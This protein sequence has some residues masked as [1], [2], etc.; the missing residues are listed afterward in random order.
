M[1]VA[2][3]PTEP[4]FLANPEAEELILGGILFDSRAIAKVENILSPEHFYVRSHATIYQTALELYRS[5]L[6]TDLMTVSHHLEEKGVLEQIGGISR[7]ATLIERTVSAANIDSYARNIVRKHWEKRE[8]QSLSYKITEWVEDPNY[9]PAQIAELIIHQAQSLTIA[10]GDK[11]LLSRAIAQIKQ[12]LKIPDLS[13]LQQNAKL[14]HLRSELKI[15]PYQWENNFVQAAKKE[16]R[17]ETQKARLKLEILAYVQTL[18]PYEKMLLKSH[19]CSHY[20]LSKADLNYLV[21]QT[22]K[23]LETMAQSDFS[24]DEFLNSGTVGLQW[25]VPGI[26]PV[27]ETV[28][29]AA[30]AKT[31]KTLLATDIAYGVLTGERV[32]GEQP[33]VKG[34]VLLVT[35]DESGNSTKRRLRA[36]GFDLLANRND[37]RII[38]KLDINDLSPLD[39]ALGE[40]QP[41]LVIIDSLTSITDNLGV[42]E[43]DPEFARSIY[44]LKNLI[45]S[46]GASGILI[47]HEN[48]CPDAKGINQVSGSARIVAATWGVLQ[49]KAVNPDDEQ[50]PRRWLRVKPREGQAVCHILKLNPKDLWA[51]STIFDYVGEFGDENGEK[52]TQGQRVLDLLAR[53]APHGLDYSEIDSYLNIG[54][55]LYTVLDRLEDRQLITK[56][57]SLVN[58][59]RWMYC[60][61]TTGDD[62]DDG[63]G[64]PPPVPDTPPPTE[65]LSNT[66]TITVSQSEPNITSSAGTTDNGNAASDVANLSE[67]AP[68]NQVEVT[69]LNELDDNQTV[70]NQPS[71]PAPLFEIGQQ[72]E[73]YIPTY[74]LTQK[75]R[76]IVN[77]AFKV[78]EWVYLLNDAANTWVH[79]RYLRATVIE[80]NEGG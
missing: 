9:S 77:R 53:F 75:G 35:S 8:L 41:V 19:I 23:E 42:S 72:V 79:E 34:K 66:E 1:T 15:N 28:L 62:D 3:K 30:L 38:T 6:P 76:T 14:E 20:R 43:K 7:L 5:G 27:G 50:D 59:R 60:L 61:P 36:K 73:R 12:I 74:D 40:H 24:F 22:Q 21:Q 70:E 65:S 57:R 26:L 18:D 48:K 46:Y 78:F 52:R 56:Q 54:R 63:G 64:Q 68:N 33:G 80:D 25:L 55:S 10:S 71:K 29:L 16:L 2:N 13:E 32:L 4:K 31:G 45:G 39:K 17:G 58:P 67:E 37:L 49:L 51:S 44:H 47:H 69:D 11:S